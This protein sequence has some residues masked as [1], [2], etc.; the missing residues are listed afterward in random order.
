MAD[1]LIL[2]GA[3]VPPLAETTIV[4]SDGDWRLVRTLQ[5][6]VYT[7]ERGIYAYTGARLWLPTGSV[8]PSSRQVTDRRWLVKMDGETVLETEDLADAL[9]ALWA[10]REASS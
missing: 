5:P 6:G 4:Q 2:G 9:A 10:A 3:P 1:I 8:T 7:L